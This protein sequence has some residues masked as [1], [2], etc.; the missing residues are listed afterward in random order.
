M[1]TA[2][3]YTGLATL[4]ICAALLLTSLLTYD[5]PRW[6]E[7]VRVIVCPMCPVNEAEVKVSP[8]ESENGFKVGLQRL[9]IA[10]ILIS[11]VVLSVDFAVKYR[12]RRREKEAQEAV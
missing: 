7:M 4:W 1:G 5:E 6:S 11:I 8:S 12:H 10:G 3:Y 9:A 2:G